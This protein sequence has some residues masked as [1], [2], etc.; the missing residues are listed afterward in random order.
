MKDIRPAW[1]PWRRDTAIWIRQ[2][3]MK[4]EAQVGAAVRGQR[5]S[6]RRDFCHQQKSG[7]QIWWK[8]SRKQLSKRH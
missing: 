5:R 2:A 7:I 8:E 3:I 1:M 6:E 4:N